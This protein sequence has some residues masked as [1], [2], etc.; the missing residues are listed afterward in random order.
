MAHTN[1]ISCFNKLINYF[2]FKNGKMYKF[3]ANS[4]EK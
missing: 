3:I 4:D 2:K 1:T